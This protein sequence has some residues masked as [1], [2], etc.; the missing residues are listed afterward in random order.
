MTIIKEERLK[1]QSDSSQGFNVIKQ[2]ILVS[3]NEDKHLKKVDDAKKSAIHNSRD[4]DEF[5]DL[6]STCH[7]KPIQKN[8]FNAPA[9][10]L[11]SNTLYNGRHS[12]PIVAIENG[13]FTSSLQL[14]TSKQDFYTKISRAVNQWS[15]IKAHEKDLLYSWFQ[16]GMDEEVFAELV[17]SLDAGDVEAVSLIRSLSQF[18]WFSR[19]VEFLSTSERAKLS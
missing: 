14:A 8:E 18:A 5:K 12:E 9:K 6:V 1:W 16:A 10:L 13:K 19:S 7:L 4:Y 3:H 17:N 2:D 11:S 15:F